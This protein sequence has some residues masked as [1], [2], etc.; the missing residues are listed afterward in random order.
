MSQLYDM[1]L[2]VDEKIAADKLDAADI[3]GK[4]GLKVG[5]LIALISP[6]TPDKP[7]Q[8]TR[9]KVAAKEILNLSL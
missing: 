3:R 2:R 1:K 5:L 8:I 4:I 7:E 9:F 6:N